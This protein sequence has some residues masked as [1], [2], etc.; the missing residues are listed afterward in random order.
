M[1]QAEVHI[2]SHWPWASCSQ[3]GISATS[4]AV[5]R[6]GKVNMTVI[7]VLRENRDNVYTCPERIVIP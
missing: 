2:R 4:L 1:T 6:V 3:R 5:E 7:G